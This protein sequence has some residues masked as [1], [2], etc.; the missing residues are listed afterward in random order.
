[1][2]TR[3][4]LHAIAEQVMAGARYRAEGRIGLHVTPGGFATPPFGPLGRVLAID[5]VWFTVTDTE[6]TRRLPLAATL[7]ELAAAAGTTPGAPDSYPAET[8]VAPGEPLVID[9]PMLR[10]LTAWQALGDEALRAAATQL[11]AA[12]VLPPTLWPEHFD[13]GIRIGAL[14]LGVSLGDS[15][16]ASPYLYVGPDHRPLP[17]DGFWN[18][19]FGAARTWDDVATVDDAVAF[20]LAGEAHTATLS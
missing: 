3:S 8:N 5:D 6:G 17:D 10:R 15:S 11:G 9:A 18:A 13:V 1:M 14:N 7:D 16:V 12:D 4:T 19:P 20:F 2:G